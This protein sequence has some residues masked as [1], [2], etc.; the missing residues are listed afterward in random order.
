MMSWRRRIGDDGPKGVES[1]DVSHLDW[2]RGGPYSAAKGRRG[3][4]RAR[5]NVEEDGGTVNFWCCSG[6][7]ERDANIFNRDLNPFRES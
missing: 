4:V 6:V 2:R 1:S 7:E 5:G 3:D